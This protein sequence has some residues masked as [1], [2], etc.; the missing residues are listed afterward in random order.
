MASV[1]ARVPLARSLALTALAVAAI[2]TNSSSQT[3]SIRSRTDMTCAAGPVWVEIADLNNDG[4]NDMF[5]ANYNSSSVSVFLGNGS[6]GFLPRTD[7][8][9][10]IGAFTVRTADLNNDLRV[11]LLVANFSGGSVSVLLGNGNGTFQPAITTAT[12]AGCAVA[13]EA[14]LNND[15]FV[16]VVTANYNA[17]TMSVL[18][19][20]GAGGFSA[21]TDYTTATQPNWVS[22]AD[23]DGDGDF[24]MI[25]A[26][27]G[28][29]NISYFLGNGNG[30]FQSKVDFPMG[31][32]PVTLTLNDFN[33]DN[34]ADVATANNG[35]G[36]VSVRLNNGGGSFGAKQDFTA[37]GGPITITSGDLNLDGKIDLVTCNETTNNVSVLIGTGTGGFAAHVDYAV[38]TLP[39][40][41]TIG[42]ATGDGEP[43]I[44]TA[45]QTTNNITL[46]T[47]NVPGGFAVGDTAAALVALD[48]N[49]V[50]RSLSSFAGKWVLLDICPQ[51]CGPCNEMALEVAE[52]VYDTFTGVLP[53]EWLTAML[54]GATPTQGSTQTTAAN[55]RD[56]YEITSP[57]LHENG[58]NHGT[59]R[60][61]YRASRMGAF[62]TRIVV[63]PT[64]KIRAKDVGAEYGQAIVNQISALAGISPPT[65]PGSGPPPPP[66]SCGTARP[67]WRAMQS[68]TLDVS[69][70]AAT[71]SIP[72]TPY[73]T[74]EPP[75][76]VNSVHVALFG[77]VPSC[78]G[79]SG[80]A[81]GEVFAEV[82][83]ITGRENVRIFLGTGDGTSP[84][85]APIQLAQPWQVKIKN[86]VWADGLSRVVE[87]SNN[88]VVFSHYVANGQY[89]YKL[90]TIH[91]ATTLTGTQVS[92]TSFPLGNVPD[93]S[94]ATSAFS[95]FNVVLRHQALVSVGDPDHATRVELSAPSPN[96]ANRLST[97][98]W[99]MPVQGDARLTVM[100]VAGR[101]VRDLRHGP[102]A[103]GSHSATWDLRDD[104]GKR[105][106]PGLYFAALTAGGV[107]RRTR[108]VVLE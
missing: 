34:L 35:A 50:S 83:S 3:F 66:P 80:A 94:P 67:V 16:D 60:A 40:G 49:N 87:Q 103:A 96:P 71:T 15:T 61:W 37:T 52:P 29:N 70:G 32:H 76:C 107:V 59:I 10:G 91:P 46:L 30:T 77:T 14:E 28:S 101:Q 102:T 54:D 23:L 19:G 42:D 53:F 33:G 11:D 79:T 74:G 85:A 25:T 26:N 13:M 2:A 99:S 88:P 106:A 64:G 69:Y 20:N 65:F 31:S 86:I 82:D 47:G 6:G 90:T 18:F 21:K 43:D 72:M 9:T 36:T 4:V 92:L 95:V 93:I 38:G 105:V 100:D 62:P 58:S 57:V 17:N 78:V 56:K 97:I 45:N 22:G 89:T 104:A 5:S 41:V 48:Q 1:F 81:F 68:A 44:V 98:R 27:N 24:E 51:W 12:G 63:D 73:E 75:Y 8:A 55:W 7:Y 108:L 39:Q 84:G